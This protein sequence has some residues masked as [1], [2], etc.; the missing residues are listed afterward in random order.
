MSTATGRSRGGYVATAR[1]VV[2]T[3]QERN[4]TFLAASFAYYA[5]VSLIPLLLLTLVIGSIVGG[6]AFAQQLVSQV[7]DVLSSSGQELI[8]EAVTNENGRAGASVV[9]VVTLIWSGLKVFR[10]IDLAF[11]EVYEGDADT[12]L[13]EQV[14]NGLAVVLA[15]G[16]AVVLMVAISAAIGFADGLGLPFVSVWGRLALLVG[17]TLAFLPIYYV[18]PPVPVTVREVLPGTVVAA[19]G[20]TLLQVL[21]QIYSRNAGSYEAYGVLGGILLFLTWLYFAGTLLLVGA[22]VNAVLDGRGVSS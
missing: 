10:G 22:T 18:M 8:V 2:A 19:V 7:S 13:L 15:T 6:E 17:L 3:A 5:F 12:S 20:W 11:D 21:F 14:K 16:L 1:S 4:V 9:G